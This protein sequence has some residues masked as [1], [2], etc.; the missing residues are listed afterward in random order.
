MK[1]IEM[2]KSLLTEEV[3]EAGKNPDTDR[4]QLYEEMLDFTKDILCK[5][6][7]AGF[8]TDTVLEDLRKRIDPEPETDYVKEFVHF[9]EFLDGLNVFAEDATSESLIKTL[10]EFVSVFSKNETNE[11]YVTHMS[12]YAFV[13]QIG[14][15]SS[16]IVGCIGPKQR[17][18]FG[19][20]EDVW[21]YDDEENVVRQLSAKEVFEAYAI[22]DRE[23][24]KHD[25]KGAPPYR[26]A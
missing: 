5:I 4:E 24:E 25:K 19:R 23:H 3:E 13:V 11:I 21:C 16:R 7:P 1:K 15:V 14:K 10:D 17:P 9:L 2:L 6:Y 8:D 26:H 22:H 20:Y 12:N 18:F